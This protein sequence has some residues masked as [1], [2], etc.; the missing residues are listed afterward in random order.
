[1][2]QVKPGKSVTIRGGKGESWSI[3]VTVKKLKTPIRKAKKGAYRI[4]ELDGTIN[5][6]YTYED[7]YAYKL[8]GRYS[9]KFLNEYG[10]KSNNRMWGQIT[11]KK[12]N[13][14]K[15]AYIMEKM[16]EKDIA[17]MIKKN[18]GI[19]IRRKWWDIQEKYLFQ[20]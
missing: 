14:N 5:S 8:H 18:D 2:S 3:Q 20:Y 4:A 9:R 1:M 10:S 17:T 15:Y 6:R 19:V 7:D 13:Y 11:G 12:R 16:M